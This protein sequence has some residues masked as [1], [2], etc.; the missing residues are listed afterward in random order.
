MT[1]DTN[2]CHG[3]CAIVPSLE[4]STCM[5]AHVD[6]SDHDISDDL[7][8][9]NWAFYCKDCLNEYDFCK[10]CVKIIPVETQLK[11]CEEY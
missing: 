10:S 2:E 7:A 6:L 9:P 11:I 1:D 5:T 4:V 3:C 8:C